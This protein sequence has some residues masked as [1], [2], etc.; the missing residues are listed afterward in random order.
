[1]N[2]SLKLAPSVEFALRLPLYTTTTQTHLQYEAALQTET[3]NN[4]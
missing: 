1:M 3:N 2:R 4:M